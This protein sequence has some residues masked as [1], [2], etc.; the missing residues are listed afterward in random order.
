[1]TSSIPVPLAVVL[2]FL[3]AALPPLARFA[4]LRARR[5]RAA[6]AWSAATDVH[7][8]DHE[9]LPTFGI[10]REGV[11]ITG[12]LIEIWPFDR[13][14]PFYGALLTIKLPSNTP[15]D[16]ALGALAS[17]PGCPTPRCLPP[18][19]TDS[20]QLRLPVMSALARPGEL[21]SLLTRMVAALTAGDAEG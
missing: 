9:G 7:V 14:A 19:V 3:T 4:W 1:M 12:E 13:R 2:A 18:R 16:T 5:R 21:D 11:R 20:H 15:A 8:S 6:R 10:D 17:L